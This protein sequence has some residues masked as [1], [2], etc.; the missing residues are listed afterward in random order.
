MEFLLSGDAPFD[1]EIRVVGDDAAT[2]HAHRMALAAQSLYFRRRLYGEVGNEAGG[3]PP[4]AI[5][6][7]GVSPEAFGAVLHYVYNDALPEEVTNKS[8]NAAAF[9][10]RELFEAADMYAMD[11]MKLLCANNLCRFIDVDTVSPIMEIAEAHSCEL[12]KKARRNYMKRRRIL[13]Q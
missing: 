3:A 13:A 1:L 2:F 6:V 4:S 7:H 11:R 12:L 10:A 8:G 9:M 5:D